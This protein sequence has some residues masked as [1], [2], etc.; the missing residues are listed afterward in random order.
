MPNSAYP[1][2]GKRVWVLGHRGMVGGGITQR[3]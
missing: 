1:L 2:K 3:A